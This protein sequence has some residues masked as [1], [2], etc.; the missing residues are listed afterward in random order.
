M[1]RFIVLT[2]ICCLGVQAIAGAAPI[3]IVYEG[4]FVDLE[5]R[6]EPNGPFYCDVHGEF[7]IDE[8]L[9]NQQAVVSASMVIGEKGMSLLAPAGWRLSMIENNGWD[10]YEDYADRRCDVI[11][12]GARFAGW[13]GV[14]EEEYFDLGIEVEDPSIVPNWP[15]FDRGYGVTLKLI[16]PSSWFD[17]ITN[18]ITRLQGLATFDRIEGMI[19]YRDWRLRDE[20]TYSTFEVTS[21]EV[22]PEPAAIKL[23]SMSVVL[24][25]SFLTRNVRRRKSAVVNLTHPSHNLR[26]RSLRS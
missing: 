2:A 8:T 4:R 14:M 25:V 19:D 10:D 23:L 22:V 16:G 24:G 9:P 20:S 18:P 17:P 26:S 3:R 21:I 6:G 1:M 15:E 13:D 5:R 12:F 7:I 11:W